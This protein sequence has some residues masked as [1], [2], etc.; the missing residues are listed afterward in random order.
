MEDI[1]HYAQQLTNN[2]KQWKNVPTYDI[3]D[4]DLRKL[5]RK[6]EKIAM[7]AR[8]LVTDILWS[9]PLFNDEKKALETAI[10]GDITRLPGVTVSFDEQGNLTVKTP[11]LLSIRS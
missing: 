11:P 8:H 1:E 4:A 7:S 3:D 9:R 2:A 5:L 6:A 10:N